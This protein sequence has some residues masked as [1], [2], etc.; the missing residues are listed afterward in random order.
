[1]SIE[2]KHAYRFGFLK[3]E[4]WRGIRLEALARAGARCKLCGDVDWANDAHHIRYRPKWADTKTKD[5]VVLCR[6]DHNLVHSVMRQ[7]PEMSNKKVVDMIRNDRGI[8]FGIARNWAK[9]PSRPPNASSWLDAKGNR[10]GLCRA[11]ARLRR[12]LT[13]KLSKA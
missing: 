5:L 3:S 6:K 7:F 1:M 10:R 2:N 11:I 4:E 8:F 9:N 13:K 12:R